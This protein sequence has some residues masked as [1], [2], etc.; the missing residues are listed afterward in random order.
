[1]AA[2]TLI[3]QPTSPVSVIVAREA[4]ADTLK[5]L[6]ECGCLHPE[7]LE[8]E[9]ALSQTL[10]HLRSELESLAQRLL[11]LLRA[12]EEAGAGAAEGE[13]VLKISREADI[14]LSRLLGEIDRAVRD[15]ESLVER[16]SQLRNPESEL[17]EML[18]ALE[19]YSFINIDIEALKRNSYIR[20]KVYRVPRG[21]VAGFIA[22]L[23]AIG[24][25]AGL[26]ATGIE[27]GME[28][29]VVAYPT[30]LEAEV[31]KAALRSRAVPL[32]VPEGLPRIPAEA[33]SR[34][35][36]ELEELPLALRRHAP[37]I[38]EALV[39]VEAAKRLLSLLEATRIT[40]LLA[41]INGYI[42]PGREGDL[43][44]ALASLG[45]GYTALVYEETGGSRG[46]GGEAGE[47]LPPSYF[48]VSEKLA[49]F[50]SLL[51]MAGYPRPR[52]FV[53][54]VLMAFT[55]PLVYG[56]MFPD[57]GHGLV[58]LL[59]G[60]Y[61]FY[62]KMGDRNNG[63]LL[64]LFGAVAMAT[65]FL[66]GEFFGPLP[67]VAGWL[68]AIWHV[69]PPLASPLHPFAEELAAGTAG[70]NLAGEATL[71][72]YNA[73]YLSVALGALLMA[74][75]SWVSVANGVLIGDKEITAVGLGKALVFTGIAVVFLV[76]DAVGHGATPLERAGSVLY[77]AGL[78]LVPKTSLGMAARLMVTI[79]LLLALAAPALFGHG[80]AGERVM[81]G[82]VEAFDI[83][84]MAIGNTASF[85][86]IM[87]LMLAHSGLMFGFAILAVVG[88]PVLGGIAYIFGNILVI[89]LE[90]LVAYAHSL[91]LHFYEMFS[92]FYLDGG[93]PYTPVK[94]PENVRLVV[95]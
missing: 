73:I 82:I 76:G 26:H 10:R 59:A 85:M 63:R 15:V 9:G 80:S 78:A 94:L 88:G 65:G 79:G 20:A 47:K 6:A 24:A 32:E 86:R 28:T 74:L 43:E 48:R 13:Q 41:V 91:R 68:N 64:M 61:L 30:W 50:A 5:L 56:L 31:G 62:R 54:A 57:M 46:H 92:K 49:P 8:A 77:D 42:A 90:A 27:E 75:S 38:R 45:G 33:I 71:L 89:G 22:D 67:A 19:A 72:I 84:L 1:M 55:L 34:V 58:L 21:S 87:G 70:E 17:A 37:R 83:L 2:S 12:A 3:A 23:E 60:Y 16:L 18:A 52:E 69:H 25:I 44:E 95:E 7:P 35:R 40:R 11:E 53:P 36:R 4:L 39:K 93:R 29:V 51:E 66:A 81:N 14:G